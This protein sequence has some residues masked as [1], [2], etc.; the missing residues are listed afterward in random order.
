MW[1]YVPHKSMDA[2]KS[3]D[4][5]A[6]QQQ[7]WSC[8]C[9]TRIFSSLLVLPTEEWQQVN[10]HRQLWVVTGDDGRLG[11]SDVCL[12]LRGVHIHAFLKCC[13]GKRN[14]DGNRYLYYCQ[15]HT[16]SVRAIFGKSLRQFLA[17]REVSCCHTLC[18]T[19]FFQCS[20]AT[21][22]RCGSN[23]LFIYCSCTRYSRLLSVCWSW[24]CNSVRNKEI[25]RNV[26]RI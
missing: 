22:R 5:L 1:Q 15:Y 25:L 11:G 23:N 20:L 18:W 9:T 6:V 10:V 7:H 17:A 13:I 8:T 19:P 24:R 16:S 21:S 12:C 4:D 3:H 2:T 14:L 26:L